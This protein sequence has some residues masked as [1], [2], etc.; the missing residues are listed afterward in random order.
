[1]ARGEETITS[2]MIKEHGKLDALL[3]QFRRFVGH[4]YSNQKIKPAATFI[5]LENFKKREFTHIEMEDKVFTLNKKIKTMA[6]TKILKK[7][8]KGIKDM[9]NQIEKESKLGS[10]AAEKIRE[11]Q[12][13][14]R[15]HIKL[16]EK[17]F[18]PEIDKKLTSDERKN[19]L[20]YMKELLSE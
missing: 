13:F 7:Q 14:L 19:L 8:H 4:L 12:S 17:E 5:P 6:I 3:A 10:P 1:M 9:M 20:E 2:F 15:S 11:L 16:E 18:Y